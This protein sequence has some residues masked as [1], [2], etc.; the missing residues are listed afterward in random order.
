MLGVS[1]GTN[2]LLLSYFSLD[3]FTPE[4]V[5]NKTSWQK[6]FVKSIIEPQGY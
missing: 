6:L 1:D 2:I 5:A 3:F 4:V